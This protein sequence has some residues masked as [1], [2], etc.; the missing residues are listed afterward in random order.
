MIINTTEQ[1]GKEGVNGLI[2]LTKKK[3][4]QE[5]FK[6]RE[7]QKAVIKDLEKRGIF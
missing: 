7:R 1:K 2:E 3:E 5:K 6:H 4:R